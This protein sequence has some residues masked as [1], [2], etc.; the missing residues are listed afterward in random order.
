M[1]IRPRSR[2]TGGTATV[3]TVRFGWAIRSTNDA[4]AT[5]VANTYSIRL[6]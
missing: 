2:F 6:R 1:L 3:G 4:N 5:F